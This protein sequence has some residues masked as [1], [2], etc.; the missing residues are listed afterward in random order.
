MSIAEQTS[1]TNHLKE[2][3]EKE[4]PLVLF[5]RVAEHVEVPK[6]ITDNYNCGFHA[7]EHLI[8]N[9]CTRIAFL[10]IS[11]NLSISK[12]R[13]QGYLEA[14]KKH[15]IKPENSLLISCNKDDV[16]N[17]EL[18]RKLFKSKNRP[19][20]IFASVEKLAMATYELCGE[21]G[22]QIPRDIKVITFS[23]SYTVGLLNPSL[24]AITQPAY[25]MGR[26]AASILFKL[27]EKKGHHFLKETTELH[28]TLIA[29]NSTKV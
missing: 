14:L 24:S 21:L 28:S 11:Q 5:D 9:G 10:S 29:R 22:L 12:I 20:G 25:E 26:E 19:D 8:E 1:D 7:T 13:M 2:L 15:K 27:I 16:T 18:I 17:K 6:V 4:I 23:N 3:N